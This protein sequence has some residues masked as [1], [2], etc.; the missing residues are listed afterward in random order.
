LET[1][2]DRSQVKVKGKDEFATKMT[3]IEFLK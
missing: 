3:T 1:T 2:F